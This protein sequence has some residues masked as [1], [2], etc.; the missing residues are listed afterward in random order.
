MNVQR[1]LRRIQ[2]DGSL[3]PTAQ[4]LRALHRRHLLAI[5]FE[6]LDIHLGEPILLDEARIYAKIIEGR[7]G[8]YCY[9]LN[10]IFAWLLQQL[11]YSVTYLSARDPRPDGGYRP[12]F[13][14][15]TLLVQVPDEVLSSGCGTME[16]I[17][18]LADVGWGILS[19]SR[20]GLMTKD[21][22][23]MIGGPTGSSTRAAIVSSGSEK[24]TGT[25]N[26]ISALA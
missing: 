16:P 1:Y 6:N 7:R 15:L 9:E 26:R 4:T 19:G 20:C 21:C 22:T 3:D 11:G 8:G 23:Y 14:H 24:A 2:Y 5:P 25:G 18:W 17:C 13:D 12:E 10:G